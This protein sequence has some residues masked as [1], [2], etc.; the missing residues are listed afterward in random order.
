MTNPGFQAN[1]LASNPELFLQLINKGYEKS[2]RT[3]DSQSL[4]DRF[5]SLYELVFSSLT[6][7]RFRPTHN[8]DVQIP[9]TYLSHLPQ[10][11]EKTFSQKYIEINI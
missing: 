5:S 10:K 6:F 7:G 3:V 2:K 9:L 8:V 4:V 1:H 11:H